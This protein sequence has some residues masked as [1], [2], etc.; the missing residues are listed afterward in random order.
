[1]WPNKV[2]PN[3]VDGKCTTGYVSVTPL[4]LSLWT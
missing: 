1:M 2:G 4:V 3:Y